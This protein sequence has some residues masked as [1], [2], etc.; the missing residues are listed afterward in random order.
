MVAMRIEVL[1]SPKQY[2]VRDLAEDG[3]SSSVGILLEVRDSPPDH[4]TV[5]P[6][7]VEG[8]E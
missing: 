4:V 5:G 2:L 1:Y 8:G 7:R 3:Q 6:G